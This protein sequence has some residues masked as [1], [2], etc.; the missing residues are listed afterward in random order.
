MVGVE[1]EKQF[2]GIGFDESRECI[3]EEWFEAFVEADP[4]H[5]GAFALGETFDQ[6]FAVFTFCEQRR[7]E[8]AFLN[9]V[10]TDE[11]DIGNAHRGGGMQNFF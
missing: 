3:L 10:R 9:A 8:I 7:I 4:W 11:I 6:I 2:A 1:I 5:C